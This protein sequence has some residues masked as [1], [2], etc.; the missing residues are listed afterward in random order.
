MIERH[1]SLLGTLPYYY[2]VGS[3]FKA[4]FGRRI[5]CLCL[6]SVIFFDVLLDGHLSDMD[7]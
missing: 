3:L 4:S 5:P 6:S 2:I 1:D 7:I